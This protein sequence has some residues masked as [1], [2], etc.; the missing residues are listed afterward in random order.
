V[1]IEAPRKQSSRRRATFGAVA[2]LALVVGGIWLL[3]LQQQQQLAQR[4]VISA[5]SSATLASAG[6]LPTT[7]M[8]LPTPAT[9][10][11]A[12]PTPSA[13]GNKSAEGSPKRAQKRV[14]AAAKDAPAPRPNAPDEDTLFPGRK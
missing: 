10:S 4:S 8:V 9:G 3:T 13:A 11:S 6:P 1:A 7:L 12:T 14:S 2:L 5:P